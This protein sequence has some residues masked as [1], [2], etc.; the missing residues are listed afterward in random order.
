[1]PAHQDCWRGLHG[2]ALLRAL[3][4]LQAYWEE[5]WLE[6]LY[7]KM[8]RELDLSSRIRTLNRKLD[9]AHQ[10]VEVLRND[11]SEKHHT[12]LE[13]IIIGLIAIEVLFG[14]LHFF[15]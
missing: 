5:P 3:F 7:H 9:Y 12:R 13:I 15:I 10:V 8:S 2:I 11:I 1:V 14:F 4:L 6:E